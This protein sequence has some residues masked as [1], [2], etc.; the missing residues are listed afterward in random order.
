M[1]ENDASGSLK[2]SYDRKKAVSMFSDKLSATILRLCEINALTYEAAADCCNISSRYFGSIVRCKSIPSILVLEKLCTGFHVTPNGLLLNLALEQHINFR[3]PMQVTHVRIL[4]YHNGNTA[5]P[6]CP[7]CGASLERE[8]Q[9]YCDR[10]GQ[11]LDWR[12]FSTATVL[13]LTRD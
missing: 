9:N 13:Q 10:C 5:Y 8:Y 11:C 12:N 1:R 7:Q 4:P 6:V 3:V 2:T